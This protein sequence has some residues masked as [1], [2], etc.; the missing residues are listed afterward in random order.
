MRGIIMFNEYTWNLYRNGEGKKIIDLFEHF[1][2]EKIV[3][4]TYAE[5]IKIL[6]SNYC[7]CSAVIEDSYAQLVFLSEN[8]EVMTEE[9]YEFIELDATYSTEDFVWLYLC[10]LFEED[11]EKEIFSIF[12]DNMVWFS[13]LL[14]MLLPDKYIPYYFKCNFNI[15]KSMSEEFDFELPQ[16]PAKKDYSERVYYYCKISEMFH[17]FREKNHLSLSELYA[18]IYDYAPKYI[19]GIRSYIIT[20]I[21]KATSSYFIGGSQKD[22]FYSMDENTILCWQCS[23][24][25]LVGDYLIMYLRTPDSRI[26]STWRSVSLGFNDPFF[27][28]YRCTYIGHPKRI[29]PMTLKEMKTDKRI[30]QLSIVRK[31]MQGVNGTEI[32]PSIFNYIVE[33]CKADI[34]PFELIENE[35][36]YTIQIE[37]DVE[38]YLI[39]PLI[40]KLGYNQS[41]YVKQLSMKV[42]NN[43]C[44]L[45]PDFV[46]QPIKKQGYYGAFAVIE[47][48]LKISNLKELEKAKSQVRSYSKLLNAKYSVIVSKDKIWMTCIDDDYRNFIIETSWNEVACNIDEFYKIKKYL[49]K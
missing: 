13:T 16:I 36:N 48:K 5:Q 33:K 9:Y 31:N 28:Y 14:S 12:S 32:P 42:G 21:P 29:E 20:D 1:L 4:N 39:E 44:L 18:F 26:D 25:T 7:P 8:L 24:N 6:H 41:D 37:K 19:G 45:I 43:N 3:T 17:L 2:N 47:A 46:L 23:P 49:G 35:K 27:Y 34:K 22:T 15:L 38:C 11:N 40:K 10:D 30:S